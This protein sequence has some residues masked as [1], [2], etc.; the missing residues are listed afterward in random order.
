M[1]AANRMRS[2][3]PI[4][5]QTVCAMPRESHGLNPL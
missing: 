4:R 1:I 3:A 5:I 2:S